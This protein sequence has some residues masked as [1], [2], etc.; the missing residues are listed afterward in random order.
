MGREDCYA[1]RPVALCS[2]LTACGLLLLLS[3]LK[4][5]MAL[6]GMRMVLGLLLLIVAG[7]LFLG[8]YL[9]SRCAVIVDA[10]GIR[11][12]EIVGDWREIR[13]PDVIS[14]SQRYEKRSGRTGGSVMLT[15]KSRDGD[16]VE[17]I[18]NDRTLA[19]I[20]RYSPVPVIESDE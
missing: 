20:R 11:T 10:Q 12:H 3:G 17:V 14:V 1:Y 8:V 4:L 18:R 6:R 7:F 9:L 13:W 16:D 19:M 15:V 2:V 5:I